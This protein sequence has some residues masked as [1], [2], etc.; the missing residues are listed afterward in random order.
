MGA[1]ETND[2]G[3]ESGS[4][5]IFVRSGKNWNQQ[6]RLAAPDREAQDHFGQTVSID[7]NTTIIGVPRD[8]DDGKDSGVAFIFFRD[9]DTWK[10]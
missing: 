8:D 2:G 7:R 10:Q 9:R 3:D 6:V 5:Y 4:A 1:P